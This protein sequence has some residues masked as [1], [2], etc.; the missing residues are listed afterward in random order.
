MNYLDLKQDEWMQL[1][2]RLST[3]IKSGMLPKAVNTPEKAMLIA[4]KGAELG[5]SPIYSL[6]HINVIQGKPTIS[7]E[8]ML[9]LAY[10]T[11]KDAEIVYVKLDKEGCKI[12]ARRSPNHEYSEFSFSIEDAKRAGLASKDNWRNYPQDMCRNRAVSQC[13]RALFPDAVGGC[14]YVEEEL[15]G[16]YAPPKGEQ[17]KKDFDAME[18]D[19]EVVEQDKQ[20]TLTAIK[21]A[22]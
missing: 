17:I 3:L 2:K 10:K 13:C 8:L 15:G 1:G 19:S 14:S 12:K 5:L 4:A 9:S 20:E 6:T 11:C 16:D 18:V 21:E 22:Q 7:S